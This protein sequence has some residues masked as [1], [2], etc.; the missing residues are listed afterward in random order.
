MFCPQHT[1]CSEDSRCASKSRQRGV[2]ESSESI[3]SLF[4]GLGVYRPKCGDVLR[5]GSKGRMAHSMSINVCEW[6][7]LNCVFQLL[8]RAIPERFRDEYRTH[9]KALYK[10]PMFTLLAL[11]VHLPRRPLSNDLPDFSVSDTNWE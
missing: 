3:V 8:T 9:Y 5:L 11:L 7:R 4:I 6:H 10:R 1:R 2:R